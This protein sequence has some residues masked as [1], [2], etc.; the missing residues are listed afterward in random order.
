[1]VRYGIM[2]LLTLLP[3][4]GRT[5]EIADMI[6]N[7][8]KEDFERFLTQT[9]QINDRFTQ[10]ETVNRYFNR[11]VSDFDRNV[12]GVDEYWALPWELVIKGR[13]DCEDY[14]IGKYITL[15]YLGVPAQNLMLMTVKVFR[16]PDHHMVL[17][18]TDD[19]HDEVVILDNVNRKILPLSKRPDLK[20][21]F[22]FNENAFISIEGTLPLDKVNKVFPLAKHWEEVLEA[23]EKKDP[24]F[25]RSTKTPLI[26]PGRVWI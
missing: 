19:Q 13:G 9:S 5:D 12:W 22:G 8:R 14:A 16:A 11:I 23:W 24:S 21:I 17:A 7:A 15:R 25:H 2:L 6:A 3:V 4:F 18:Y 20:M 10:V 1:M 26:T